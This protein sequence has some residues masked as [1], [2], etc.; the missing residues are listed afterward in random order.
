MTCKRRIL[1][2]ISLNNAISVIACSFFYPLTNKIIKIRIK[3]IHELMKIIQKNI[4]IRINCFIF[5]LDYM[6]SLY[7]YL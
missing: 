6:K 4:Y 5:K 1:I 2:L 7:T 3:A